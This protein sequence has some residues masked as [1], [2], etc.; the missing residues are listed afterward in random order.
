MKLVRHRKAFTLIELL[1]VVAIIALLI[2]ILLPS[3]SQAR[4]TARM[5]ACSATLKQ[6]GNADAFYQV[7]YN[8]F[9]VPFT[10]P[11]QSA[12]AWDYYRWWNNPHFAASLGLNLNASQELNAP[13]GLI[14]PDAEGVLDNPGSN[15]YNLHR[16]YGMNTWPPWGSWS[17]GL[18]VWGDRTVGD[19]RAYRST[20]VIRPA[21]KMFFVDALEETIFYDRQLQYSVTGEE[22]ENY[23]CCSI[24]SGY[25]VN[26]WRH[27]YRN[28]GGGQ[29]VGGFGFYNGSATGIQNVLFFDGHVAGVSAPSEQ[30]ADEEG[31]WIPYE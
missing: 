24:D 21:E 3:L 8:S 23:G 9:H 18:G 20:S 16:A 30:L 5:V 26:A 12:E 1:V 15:G 10:V 13:R 14:C 19:V 11:G 25:G 27:M 7:D 28:N 4:A 29:N 22:Y 2:S 6:F 17:D 31:F